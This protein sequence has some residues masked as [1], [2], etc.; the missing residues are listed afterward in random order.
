MNPLD[1]E[2]TVARLK[3]SV[4]GKGA[5]PVDEMKASILASIGTFTRGARQ[6]DDL[7]LLLVRYPGPN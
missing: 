6:N 3:D 5:L 1:E 7:T 2:F 4:S